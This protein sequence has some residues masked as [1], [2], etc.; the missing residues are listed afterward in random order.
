M[1]FVAVGVKSKSLLL[2]ETETRLKFETPSSAGKVYRFEN[3]KI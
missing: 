3:S 2:P 1:L